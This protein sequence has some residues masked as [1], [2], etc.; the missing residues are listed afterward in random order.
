VVGTRLRTG[1]RR[2]DP[3]YRRGCAGRP[4]TYG[5]R[6]RI[7]KPSSPTKRSPRPADYL[8]LLTATAPAQEVPRKPFPASG[9][10]CCACRQRVTL[11]R[12]ITEK[13][14]YDD[15]PRAAGKACSGGTTAKGPAQNM[16]C[17]FRCAAVSNLK[18][19]GYSMYGSNFSLFKEDFYS[20]MATTRTS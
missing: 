5:T 15:V 11:D 20:S 4:C 6:T 17:I 3:R 14:T 8:C 13:L 18:K 7:R 2:A 10:G 16:D 1:N 19:K 9:Q 12:H